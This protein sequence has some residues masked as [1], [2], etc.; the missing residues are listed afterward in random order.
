MTAA[1]APVQRTAMGRL[2][3]LIETA[4]NKVPHPV[5]MFLYLIIGV[6]VLS[7]LLA[8]AGVS[9]TDQIVVPDEI[10]VTPNY[11]EDTVYPQ[12]AEGDVLANGFH[13]EEVTIPIQGLLTTEGIRFIFTSFVSN[14][15]GFGV[16]AVTFIALLGAG[17]AEA[18]GLMGAL[19]RK[20]VASSPRRLLTLILVAVGVMASVATDAGYLILVPLGAAAFLSIGRHPLA[21]LAACFAA[22]GSVFGVNPILGPIDAMVTEVTNE[23]LG[24]TGAPP[25]TIVSNYWFSVVSSIVLAVVVALITERIIEPRLGAFSGEAVGQASE[26]DVDAAAESKGLRYAG[27]AFLAF[28][29]LVLLLTLPPGAPLRDPETGD[30]IG[31]TP[32]MDSLLFIIS[33]AFLVSGIAFGRGAG[34]FTSA[35]DVI[36]AV[37]KTFAGLA[38]LVFMLLMISQFI[39]YFNFSNIPSVLA[40]FLAEVL[41]SAGIGALPLLIGMIVV[42][43]LLDII[44]P[45]LVPKWAIF[46]PIFVPLFVQLGVPPQTGLAAYR[47]ADSPLNTV[48]PLMVYLPFMVTVAQRYQPDAGIGTIIALM[49][50]Y[51]AIIAVV[52]ILLFIVWFVL[53]LPLGPGYPVRF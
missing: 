13:I 3:D 35:N 10:P 9:V 18:G 48:T 43:M 52:W 11:Y 17:V 44:I 25:L 8:L 22:V 53:G 41:E 46:A 38:G 23:A 26:A 30:I 16:V 40:I 51:V 12:G 15:A 24:T 45:G 36:A 27:I 29:V 6:I 42:I 50:P 28:V 5:L 37:T 4:G 39:A 34:T 2:L 31:T 47:V 49:V 20:L 32:F 1:T 14:F 7:Q 19:I 33:A 21:G